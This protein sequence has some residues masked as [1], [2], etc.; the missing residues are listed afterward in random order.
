MFKVNSSTQIRFVSTENII[1]CSKQT[2][3]PV[4]VGVGYVHADTFDEFPLGLGI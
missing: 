2:D 3:I 4:P 1:I